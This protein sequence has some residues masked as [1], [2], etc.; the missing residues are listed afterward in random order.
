MQQRPKAVLSPV[1]PAIPSQLKDNG[2]TVQTGRAAR[3]H[4]I[5]LLKEYI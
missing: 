3:N 2:L 5:S 4:A 1:A